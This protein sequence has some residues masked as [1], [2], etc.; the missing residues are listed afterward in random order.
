METLDS[1][2]KELEEIWGSIFENGSNKALAE[3]HLPGFPI[4]QLNEVVA[5]VCE[6]ALKQRAPQ[7]FAP[8]FNLGRA[9]AATALNAAIDAARSIK[10]GK[11]EYFGVLA[12]NLNE[13]L[14][15]LHTMTV[16]SN[17]GQTISADISAELTQA[18]ALLNTGQRE[19]ADKVALL[20][21]ADESARRISEAEESLA[22]TTK[23]I[24]DA[25]AVITAGQTEATQ[26]LAAITA[27][28]N[29]LDSLQEESEKVFE[30]NKA[31]AAQLQSVVERAK[32]V[33]A[34]NS[35]QTETIKKLLP[36]AAGAG[37]A[38]SFETRARGLEVTKWIWFG[39]FLGTVVGLVSLAI[40][41]VLKDGTPHDIWFHLLSRLPIAAPL[42]WLGYVAAV[43]YGNVI[44]VQE[45][46]EFKKATSHAFEGYRDHL[47]ALS[48]VDDGRGQK[49]V[50]L[51]AIRTVEILAKDPL[52]NYARTHRD[53]A[54]TQEL[55][56]L[57]KQY[58]KK[59]AADLDE[60]AAIEPKPKKSP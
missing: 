7:G 16:F 34:E 15:A 46:Y 29:D 57:M 53:A 39:V 14:S 30:S 54:P 6:W 31:L 10:A 47:E 11:G 55:I 51:L 8:A 43:Q 18:I 36:G 33:E 26:K 56:E 60:A 4:V 32:V 50:E 19:L 25:L 17:K 35:K 59:G 24:T 58:F 49:A 38:H 28:Q 40:N 44:R 3:A 27:L 48:D 37:L 2:A 5:I 12:T 21:K 9:M 1:P 13:A 52:R 42:V 23:A 41:G 20:N 22:P 45:D